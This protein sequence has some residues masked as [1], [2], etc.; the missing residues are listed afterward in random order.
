[1]TQP[2]V[3]R[4]SYLSLMEVFAPRD[5]KGFDRLDAGAG[6][7]LAMPN[8]CSAYVFRLARAS[9]NEQEASFNFI[10]DAEAGAA[11]VE[12]VFLIHDGRVAY[13]AMN[14]V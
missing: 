1:V 11:T 4:L 6:K 2:G 8:G 9:G 7:C 13:K 10:N 14:G 12:V 5:S 3:K